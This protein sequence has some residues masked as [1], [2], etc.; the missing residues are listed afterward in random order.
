MANNYYQN[1]LIQLASSVQVSEK[2]TRKIGLSV[3]RDNKL[4]WT[5]DDFKTR[6]IVMLKLT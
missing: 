1:I 2:L 3:F 5:S 4:K 6:Q